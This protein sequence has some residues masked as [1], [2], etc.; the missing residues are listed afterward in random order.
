MRDASYPVLVE[1][2]AQ[3]EELAEHAQDRSVRE[4]ASEPAR[5]YRELIAQADQH[6]SRT[7]PGIAAAP[8]LGPRGA[9]PV[10]SGADLRRTNG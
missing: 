1:R 7:W 8:V 4:K 5:G 3:C 10:N 9:E 2:L 6:A